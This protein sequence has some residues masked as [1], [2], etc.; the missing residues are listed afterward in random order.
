LR[1]L[2]IE[3]ERLLETIRESAQ[4]LRG[5]EVTPEEREDALSAIEENQARLAKVMTKVVD[6]YFSVIKP[7]ERPPA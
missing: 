3:S 7:S 2:S 6:L 5:A 1:R 4:T